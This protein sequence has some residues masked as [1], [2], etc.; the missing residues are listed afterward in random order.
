[1]CASRYS[2]ALM[3]IKNIEQRKQT[4]LK[5]C[6]SIRRRQLEF[7]LHGIRFPAAHDESKDVAERSGV[8]PPLFSR[9]R[10]PISMADTPHGVYELRYF[11]SESRAG[12]PGRRYPSF[13]AEAQ[14]QEDD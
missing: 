9:A 3:L 14:G 10:P 12:F 1:M 5:V 4:I 8:H 11:F 6:E 13:T 7:L 2:S